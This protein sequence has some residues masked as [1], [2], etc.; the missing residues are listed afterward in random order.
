ML[1]VDILVDVELVVDVAVEL[2]VLLVEDAACVRLKKL[3]VMDSSLVSSGPGKIQKKKTG[4]S[5][6]SN[7]Y[8]LAIHEN[9]VLVESEESLPARGA[10]QVSIP[11]TPW[12]A[13]I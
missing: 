5:E 13:S 2:A 6:R 9:D 8:V 3:D 10:H 11:Y 1:W 4:E 7:E 12:S